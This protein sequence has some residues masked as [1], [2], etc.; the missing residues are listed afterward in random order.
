MNPIPNPSYFSSNPRSQLTHFRQS[1]SHFLTIPINYRPISNPSSFSGTKS[2]C[3][4]KRSMKAW[5][6]TRRQGNPGLIILVR[7][8][9]IFKARDLIFCDWIW[10]QIWTGFYPILLGALY[11]YQ[12]W[13]SCVRFT[14]ADLLTNTWHL[15]AQIWVEWVGSNFVFHIITIPSA[16]RACNPAE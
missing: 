12:F 7:Y 9:D 6:G 2:Q 11:S 13:S 10:S 3:A 4:M 1:Q 15:P 8:N 5:L 14:F 16:S